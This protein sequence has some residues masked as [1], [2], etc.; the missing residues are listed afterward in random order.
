MKILSKLLLFTL[1]LGL[2]SSCK[3][4]TIDPNSISYLYSLK[5]NYNSV[6]LEQKDANGDNLYRIY[7]PENFPLVQAPIV[8]WGNGTDALPDDY[9]ELLKHLSTWGF[10]VIDTYSKTTGDGSEMIGA[11]DFLIAENNNSGSIFHQKLDT[12]NIAIAG[13]SQGSGGAINGH[14]NFT[15]G[16]RIKTVIPIALPDLSFA[17]PNHKYDASLITGS[18]LVLGGVDDFIISPRS[19]NQKAYDLVSNTPAAMVILKKAGHNEIQGDG[20]LHRSFLT[21]WLAAQL[22]QDSVAQQVYS[23]SD[24]EIF[25]STVIK[26][27]LSKNL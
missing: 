9:N 1:L 27:A 19:T 24:P 21:S 18:F 16:H 7:Y 10:V 14:T 17:S 20:G 25:K 5:G 6:T 12:T 11:L 2:H 3:K 26:T 23:G 4:K 22:L 8:V 15:S 13:H